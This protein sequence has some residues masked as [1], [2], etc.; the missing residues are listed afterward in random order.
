MI[1]ELGAILSGQELPALPIQYADY[2]IWQRQWLEEGG[3]LAGQLAYWQKQLAGVPESLDLPAD[4]RRPAVQSFAGAMHE[5]TLDAELTARLKRVAEGEGATLYMV[6]LAAFQVLLHRYSGQDDICVGS[7]IA[8]RQYGETEGLIGMF[9]NTLAMRSRVQ[10][11]E[12]FAALLA[13][14]KTTCLEAYEHQDAPFEKIVELVRP[15]RNLAMGP[16]FQVMFILQ[17]VATAEA[18]PRVQ[19]YRFDTGISKFDL[20]LELTETGAGLSGLIDY[21]TAL[22]EPQTIARLARHFTALCRAIAAAPTAEVRALDYLGEAEKH[23]LLAGYNATQTQYPNDLCLPDLFAGQVARSPQRTAVVCGDDRLTYRQ[24]YEKSRDLALYLQSQGVGPDSL[25]GVCMERSLEMVVALYGIL[26][27]GGAYVPLDPDYPDDRLEHMVSDSRAAIVLT[28]EKLRGKLAT[29]VAAETRLLALDTEWPEIPANTALRQDLAPN[30]LAY[31]IYTSGSTGRPKGVMNEHRGVVNRLLWMQDA[32]GLSEQDAV[33]QK[34]PFSFDVSVWELFWP[35][36]T[37]ATLVMARPEGHKDPAYLSDVIRQHQITT[38]HFVPSMLQVFLEHAEASECLSLSR[39]VCSGEALPSAFVRRFAERLPHATLY[40]L[41]GPTE[42]AVDV[43]EWICP[44]TDIPNAIPIGH[45]IANTQIYILDQYGSPVP[46]GVAGELHIAGVQVAR[47]YLNRAELTA[48]RFVHDPFAAEAGGEAGARMYKTGDLA[49]WQDDG[50]IEYLGRNDFQVKLRGFRIELGE[51][52]ARLTEHEAVL[53]AVVVAREDRP[54]EKRLVAYYTSSPEHEV[55]SSEIR[56]FLGERLPEYMVPAVYVPLDEMPLSPNGK[57]DR[58][59]LPAPELGAIAAREYEAPQGEIEQALA[60]ICQELL[61]VERV[62]RNDDFFELGG[63]SLLATQLISKIRSR[64]DVAVPLKAVFEGGSIA[65]LGRLIAGAEKNDSSPILPADR[66]R[67][68]RL[69]L[70]FAQERLWFLTELDPDSAGYNVPAAVRICGDVDA[71]QLDRALNTIIARHENLRTVFPTEEG[72]ASQRILD[73]IDFRLERVEASDA[74]TAQA[75]CRADAATPFDLANGPLFRGKLIRLDEQEHILLLNMHHIVS[76]GWS[77]GVL[78]REL[79]AVMS[80]QELPALPIQY[81]DYSIWQR[82]WLEE[83]GRLE[84][85]LAYWQ[86]QLAGVPESLDLPADFR[87]SAVQS[88]AGATRELALDAEL[89]AQLKRVAEGEGATLYMVLLATFQV[90][91]HRYSGQDDITVGSPIANRQHGE[92]EGLIGMFVNTLAMRSRVESDEPFTALLAK[93]KSTCLEAYEHQDAPFEKI[94]ELVSPQRNLAVSPLFQVMLLLQNFD[95]GAPD[96]RI[97]PYRLDTGISKFDLTFAF[98]ETADGLTGAV[99]YSTALYKPATIERMIEHFTA[100]CRSITAKPAARVRELQLLG[101]AEQHRL[102]VELNATNADYPADQCLHQLFVER[103][104]EY[105]DKTALVCGDEQLTY[106]QLLERSRDL[107]LYLQSQGVEPD[108]RVGVCMDRSPEMVIAMLG[109]LQAGGAYVPLDPNYPQDRLAY[110]L[111]DSQASIVITEAKVLALLPEELR[112]VVV[113]DQREE[114]A[115]RVAVLKA[116]NVALEQKVTPRHLSHV[117]YTSGSTGQPKGVAIE[118]HS[119]V[120]LVHWASEVYSREQLSGVLAGTSIC[121]DLSVYEIFV[122]LANG[123]TIVLVPNALGLADLADKESVTLINTVPSAAEELVRMGA[124]PSSVK[125][126]NL[127]GEPLSVAL[128]D[129]LYETTSVEK[130]FDLYGPSED[131]TYST[132]TLRVKNGPQTIGRPIAKT[133]VYILDRNGNLQPVGVPGELH[134]AGDGLARGYL[135]RPELTAEKFIENPFEPGTRMYRT[136]DLARWQDDGTLQYLGRI[137]TQVKVRGFRIEMGEI[138][139]RLA[140]HPA[141]QDCAVIAQGEGA[142]KQLVAFYRATSDVSYDE[143]RAQLSKTLPDHMIPSAFVS[144]PAIPL[145]P[146][147][148]VDR[149]ALA[150]MDVIAGAGRE[151]VAPRNGT[152]QQLVEIWAAVLN[153]GPETI[154]VTDNF[155]E[156]GGHS[157]LATQL[158]S[159]IRAQMEVDLPLKTLFERGSVAQLAEAIASAKKSEVPAIVPADRTQYDRLPLSFSQERLWFINQLEPDSAGYNVPVV[160]RIQGEL[161]ADELDRALNVIIARHETLRTVFPSADGRASQRILDRIDFR[162]ERIDCADEETARVLCRADAATPFDLANGPLVRGKLIRLNADEHIAVLNMHH[163]VSD[164]WSLGVL[165]KELAAIVNGQELPALPIQYADYAIWQRQWL[166]EGGV[167]ETQLAYWQQK[168]AGAPESLDLPTDFLRPATRTVAGATRAFALDADLTGQLRRLAEREG[169]TLYMVLLAAFKVLLYRYSG[170]NDISVGSPIANRHYGETE[171]LIGMF[172]NTLVLRSRF[173]GDEPFTALLANVKATC[174]EA[175]E[176]QDAPFEKVVDAVRPQR[177]LGVSPL[178]QVMLVLQNF[179]LGTPDSRITPYPLENGIS[180]FDLTAELT[181]T[182]EGLA[183]ELRYSTALFAPQTIERMAGHFIALCQAIAAAPAAQ[184]DRL[185]YLGAAEKHELLVANNATEAEYPRNRCIHDLFAAQAARVPEQTAVVFGDQQLTFGE[186]HERSLGLAHLLRVHGVT[187]G[188]LV[189]LY[190]ERSPDMIVGLL[191]ILQAGGAYVPLDP[192]YPADRIRY[193]LQDAAPAVVLTQQRLRTQ[194]PETSARVVTIDAVPSRALIANG[195]TP[196]DL[197][198][199]IYTSGST[200]TPKG[201]MIRHSGVVNLWSAL[202]QAVYAG[203]DGWTRVSVN[204]SLSFDSSVKQLVQLL[205][206]RTLVLIPEDVRMDAEAMLAYLDRHQVDVLDCT[207][208]QLTALLGAAGSGRIPKAFLVGGEAISA[209]LWQSLSAKSEAAFFN[210]YGPTECTV[211]ATV[212]RIAADVPRLGR[213]I[214]NTR[215]YV[216][217]RTGQPV[218]VGVPGE[219]HI[220]GAGVARGYWNRPALTAERFIA[221]PF[222]GD[223]L[224]RTGDLARWLSD[225]TLQ[226]LGRIDTQVKVRGFRIEMGEIEARLRELP[227]IEDCAVVARG[228]GANKQLVAF[229][230]ADSEA[231]YDELRAHLAT[232][233]PDYMVPAAFVS[234]P[235]IP[236]TP[237]G[238]VDRR[239][240]ERMD[241]TVTAGRD[242]V[243]PRSEAEQQLVEIWAAVLNREPETIGVHD[244]FFELGGHSLLATQLISRVRGQLDVD[245]PLRTLFERGT[246]AQLA[247]A[248]AS[249]KKS[250]IPAIVPADRTQYEQLPLSFA[251][252][253]LWFMSQ[254]EPD[255]AGY[256]IPAAVRIHGEVDAD[257]LDRALNTIIARHETLRT[258]FPSADGRASQRI[259]DRID[260]RFERIDCADEET[261]RDLCRADAATPFDLTSGPLLRGK[262]IRLAGQEHILL[263]NV[264]HIINDGWSLGVLIGELGA[265]LNGQELPALPIQYADYAIWQRQWLEEGGILETQLAYWQQKLAGAPGTLDLAT[266][267]R[268]PGTQSFAGATHELAL[269]AELTAQLERLA[270]REGVTLYMVLLAAFQALLHRYTGQNDITVGSPIANR[271]YRETEGLIGMFVNTLALRNEVSADEPFTALLAKVKATCLE[272]YEHQDAPFEKIVDLV[273]P[274]RNLA[275]S[276]LFQVMLL[277]QNDGREPDA[278]IEPYRLD[279]G[280]S[281]FDLT[282][283]FSETANGLTGS[284]EYSTALYKPATIERMVEHFTALCRSITAKPAVRVR[285]LQLLGDAEQHRLLVDLNATDAD[286]PTDQCLHQLFVERVP[287]YADK[288]ALVCGEEQ[289]TYAQLHERSRD[290][291]LYLQS[292]GVEPD[293]RVGVCMERSPEM[294]IAML[295]ILQA[296]GAYVPLDPNYPQDRLAYMLH[297]SQASIVITEAKV[298]ALLPEG[299]RRVVV[300]DQGEEIAGRVAALKAANVTLEQKV[301]PRHLSHVIYTSGSTGQPKGVAIEHHSPVTLVHWASEVYSREQLSGVLAGTSICFDLSVYEIFVTLANGGTIVLVPNALGLADLADKASVTL[302]NTVPSAA[303]ELVRMG[304]IPSS[305]KTINLAGEPLSVALVDRLYETTSVE[306]VFDLYGPSEDTTYS[307][308]TLRVKNGPQTIGRPIAKTQVYILDASGNLQP[309]GVPGEL[310]IAGD[311]LARGYLHRPELTA[312]K[313]IE[314]PFEPGTRMY[315]TGDL[316]RWVDDG[317]LQYLGRIDTQVKVRGFRIEMGEIE[318]R[319]AEHP[320]IQDCA[321]IAQ[322]EGAAKQLVAFYRANPVIL[323]REDGEGSPDGCAG[324]A[325]RRGSFAVFAAQDDSE[326]CRAEV[327]YDDFRAHLSKTLPEYMVPAAF[328]SLA[329]IPLSPNGKVDRRALGRMD[330]IAAAGH[331]YVAPRSATERQLVEIWAAVLNREPE[332]VGVHDN[333]FELGGHSLLATQLISRVRGQLDVDLPLRTLF[334]RGTVAQLAEAVASAKKSEIPAIVPADRTQYEQ[335]P[336]SFAQERLWFMSQLEPDSAGYNIPAAVRI[337][338]EVDADELDR[339]LNTIIA[340]H[341]TL[342]TVFPS[343]DGRAS[344]RILDRIDF[345]FERIECADEE[346]ARDL[347]RADAATPFDLTSGPL[348]RGKL[349]RLD[350]NEHILLL[351]VHHIINDGWSLGVLIGEL[352][353]ILNGQELPALPIQYAD[354]AIWQRQWLEEGGVLETQLAYWQQKLAGAPGTLD[355]ATDYRRPGTQSFAGATHQLALDAELTAKL[356]RLAEREGVTLYM[357]LLAAFQTLLHRYT[358]QNDITVGSPIAN[359]QYRETEGL[360]GMFVN[361]LALRNEVSADEPFTALLA[362]VKATC[363]EAYEHQDAPFEKIVDLVSPQRNLAVSPLFQVMLLLQNDG[364]EPDARIEPY[365]LD[366]GISKFDL[367]FAFSETPNGL[368]GSVEYSTALYK[369]ATI[370]R[371]VEHFTALCRSIT[372]KP[373]ARVRELELLSDAEQHRLLVDLNATDADYP[374]DQCL[375]QLFVERVP[376]YA[377]KTALVCGEERLTYTQLHERSRDLALYLQS[378]GVEPDQRVGVCMDRS[379]EMVIAMLGILQAGGAY[380]PLDPNY[381]QDRLAYMLL[382]SQ[383]SIVITETKVLALLPEGLRR[384]VVDDQRVEIATRV[385]ALKAANVALEQKVTPR[386]LSHV[387]YTSGSTGQPKGV[388]IEHHSPVTL[389]HWASEVYSRE[390]LSGV[391]AGTSICFDLSVY[392]IFVTLA[393]G[394]TIVLVPNALGLADLA[395]KE[396]VTLINTVPSAAEELVRMGAIPSSVKTI[397]LAGEPLSVALVDKLYETTSVEKVY[398][399]YGPSEDTTYSTFTLRTKNG[400]QTIGRPIAKTQV[401]ILDRNGNLQPVGVPG[402]LHIAGDG[403]ARGYLHRP[404][405]TAEKFIENPFELGTRMYR[406]GD[407]ARWVDDG[408]LQYLGR[409][410]TQVKVRGFRIEMGEIEARLAEHPAVQDCAVIAQGEGAGKQLVAFYT[411]TSEVSYDELR[412]QLAKTLPEYMIPSAF[413]SLPAIPL[414]PNGKVDRRALG[415]IDVLAGAGREYVAPRNG[416]EQQLVEIWAAVLNRAPETIGTH[417][418]FF[419]LGGHSLL[420]TQL[421]SKIRAQM[422]VDLPLRTLFERGTVARLAEAIATAKKSELPAIVPVDRTQYE[423]LP[424]SFA[425][426]RLWFMSQLEPDNAAYNVPGA[427]RIHGEVDADELDRAFNTIIARH[428]TLRTVFPSEDGRASQRI[429][430]RVDFRLERIECADEETALNVCR[431]EAA[432]PF[433]LANGPLLRGK[434]IRLN[435]NEHIVL[436]NMHHIVNDG[437][438]LGVLIRELG[439]ILNGQE[440]P[441]LPIQYADYSIW[442]RQWL[443]EGG[444]LETQLAYWQKQLAGVP[445][446]LD[447]PADHPRP[448]VRTF[449]GATRAFTFDAQLTAGLQRIAEQQG[450]T[451]YMVLLAAFKVLLHRYTGQHDICVGSPIA[452]RQYGETE[453]LIGVFVNTLALRNQL[454]GDESFTALLQKVKATCLEAYEH[455]DAPFEKIV[456]RVSPQR[457]MALTPLFQIMFVLNAEMGEAFDERIQPYRLDA[458]IS[459]FDLT[460]EL[461]ETANGLAGTFRYSTALYKPQT[462]DRMVEHFIA[463]CRAIVDAPAAAV[464]AL[465]YLSAGEQHQLLAGYN[466]SVADYPADQC[467]PQLFAEQV[468]MH[469]GRTAVVFGGEQLTY[470][471]LDSR[472]HA[473]ALYLQSHGVGADKLVGIS[474]ERS[475][476]MVVALLGILRAGGAYVPLDPDYPSEL[477]QHMLT[478]AAPAVVLTQ[479]RFLGA[480]PGTSARLLALDREWNAI[481]EHVADQALAPVMPEQLAYVIYTSGSTGVPK[482]VMIE[483]GSLTN[484]LVWVTGFLAGE[485]I[486]TLPVVTNLSFDA[487]LKQILG[488]LVTGGTV[489]LTKGVASDPEGLL[490]VLENERG[491]GLNCVPSLWR[492]LLEVIERRPSEKIRNLRGLLLGGEELPQELIR[493]SLRIIPELKIANLYGPTEATANATFARQVQTGDV[494]I[495]RPVANTQIYILDAHRRPVPAGVAGEIYIGGVGV[496]RGYLNRPELTAERFIADPFSSNADARLYRTGDLGRW[497][498]DGNVEYLGRNDQQVKLRGYRIELGEIET[499]L[500]KHPRVKEAVVIA[501]EDEPGE[502]RLVAYVTGEA[503][504]EVLDVEELRAHLSAVVPQYMVPA[505]FVQLDAMPLTP[506][507]KVDRKALPKP[508]AQAFATKEYEPPQGEIEEVLAAIWQEILRVER[509]G[510][511]D[512]FFEL[513]GHSLS[514]VQLMAKINRRFEQLLPLSVMFTAPNVAALAKVI[515]TQEAKPGDILIPIQTSGDAR[516]VFAIP[517]AGGNV[518]SLHPLSKTLGAQRPFYGLGMVGLD[519]RTA[520]LN[521]VEETAKLNIA[522]LKTLQPN[523]PYSLIGHSYG[524]V[525]AYEMARLLLEDDEEIA[526]LTLIDTRAPAVLQETVRHD[527]AAE[528]AEACMVAAGQHD[529]DVG[530]EVERLR[531]L[532]DD[533]KVHYLVALLKEHGLD[534][535]AGQFNAFYR[536]YRANQHCYRTYT[537]PR[538]SHKL[539]VSLYRA[540]ASN[541]HGPADYGWNQLL[542]SPIRVHDV[543][544]DHFSILTSAFDPAL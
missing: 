69:P 215:I 105:A 294:V 409:I 10:S 407:L 312:E 155:F 245:L 311:G 49:R 437:W 444:V 430:E 171:A 310:H 412:A 21:S 335:L 187:A 183:G 192:G 381:P 338:G 70:S 419:E 98:S 489:V 241:V 54:G 74:A 222:G 320:A 75:L 315:R 170:Q 399:L 259:L 426:E 541:G 186:L 255:S 362:K 127:A 223:R 229:Y 152:E 65:Q 168:L 318:A 506:S 239:A 487:S 526:S 325:N 357:V 16:L 353:A 521:S 376:E 418:N 133:Q 85:Q 119:P 356:E 354:Y 18:D 128:V 451:L 165:I 5:L 490:D 11:D 393:N 387:I 411:A 324:V 214:A 72:R 111:R 237:N 424:L 218:P 361:T 401:Y 112:R 538:L 143:L 486:E 495:G 7:P 50:N 249:A 524:G 281:K 509:V 498:P 12:P 474:M 97:E 482:G 107:A 530:I 423:Q 125:T 428:E 367:T 278:R 305:V 100:L 275:V 68:D 432:M 55:S 351:N 350:E 177:N 477:L 511:N 130:V 544:A 385:A 199:T 329:A 519:G 149:R 136:G 253:R 505:A 53:E 372:A 392:E 442:Q 57:L 193:M 343:A 286:Y 250:E 394:G 429:L 491:T 90:L 191:A 473:L 44:K 48:E 27:A 198:Y 523:G 203:Q 89:T 522:A 71:D 468:A 518:L 146:N 327:A 516:P 17:N 481:E 288:V 47:G 374:T 339:A 235:A 369:P 102:L 517:A 254:L 295:G 458:G 80:G 303:E 228:E 445:E 309:I 349:I 233:L 262:L 330:V 25:V 443:E 224:Y 9:V 114:I 174:L 113:D 347:C 383:A 185:D 158:V 77:L 29:L 493:R 346:T 397:N 398:D 211:D 415:R 60:A 269:D 298:L 268:R 525:I 260:F 195:A 501:R 314:N 277:L 4:F 300:D 326:A 234:L 217:D 488:P 20:T 464:G 256:N 504:V 323:S 131:T 425:Q 78:I 355:L 118:H 197:A 457:N 520:P 358:G 208:S 87:R 232:T 243:A 341:E 352:G 531:Q 36:F 92:T 82:Q 117:I 141:V 43:T 386:H 465:D 417:D 485:G 308:Y 292:Q 453:G 321:V 420:A 106:A 164:G 252:E 378:Q 225:G 1:R 470:Q 86:Q 406:T 159:K 205:S 422:D 264:H 459:K 543:D 471:D 483:H 502:K 213:P 3:V 15:Q 121:F 433:D 427:V 535:D 463:L 542:Q 138:E 395:D 478:D 227:A 8:N 410:D 379:P 238:K 497:R 129:K 265:I 290:L 230:R 45:P 108:Q 291:A 396:S 140:E 529:A 88:F 144:L 73:R 182:A 103:V 163:I 13:K 403:L 500:A 342:R 151:Y 124:I 153:R 537:P 6:L 533:E 344:Q 304:A 514:A 539:E 359:R 476:E 446:S 196:D 285:E 475:L 405:L 466:A 209:E 220:G 150:R 287:E 414:S 439:A 94:V 440:L 126:I 95:L 261:A 30:H 147:G 404:E 441:A 134:I 145:S 38:L 467:L 307:T 507:K 19:P 157:L 266:D 454:D 436:L 52:E 201:V 37:G 274:Q 84:T 41:Y 513:G 289:L 322:G 154:G 202:E 334:E 380:V 139:A 450:G 200:G 2:S 162:F 42:A 302:I 156:L 216:L 28:Q 123:G 377:D 93:V 283:A 448:R 306:K 67:F 236:L 532:P 332:T 373:A 135:H 190:V 258:V 333:F 172:V 480:L 370:E 257:E 219:L 282:F 247:E 33:L 508:E 148:K 248:V 56:A 297:D 461:A 109:I 447:L 462:I 293:Q 527:V 328:V 494:T 210:V 169:T 540:V 132:Y 35:L 180:K 59:A 276:P 368:T 66:S 81:A 371:M 345:R 246:V 434:L 496:A 188:S 189:G 240:L 515:S 184:I 22:Y 299:L 244:N 178:F 62:G 104:P 499:Q 122:T 31:V 337:H 99:E 96:A 51:I 375:H 267:Y 384:V 460:A 301:T 492:M 207:P 79:A 296:G 173:A 24:L 161:D 63:H 402:E 166:E 167:L 40:N 212:A 34:T 469:P 340:R 101:D 270:E 204:A 484:Y 251:Q 231:S 160:V 534:V 382:D 61:H 284:V 391:L 360:I 23:L 348:L 431:A 181:E 421:V 413:V 115:A 365:R 14:V 142:S 435:A 194:L 226:Y 317:T 510:R 32:Y 452:N 536:V 271:Q 336:L 176:H 479:E 91:L 137:D 116:A 528:L 400:P 46:V 280:I 242:F 272:A 110:M 416:T 316:A 331:D 39:V 438:S 389:V 456:D 221:D 364:R 58:K 179:D 120:T 83:G 512:D 503:L 388:A 206:G 279:T 455:Q 366:T 263:L 64:L 319:L 408:T 449:A 363:L 273:S 26:R 76:D 390:Q 472:S 313:F 175:Y